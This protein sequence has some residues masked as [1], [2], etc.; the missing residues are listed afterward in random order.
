MVE[1]AELPRKI[2]PEEKTPEEMRKEFKVVKGGGGRKRS[3]WIKIG[4]G[5]GVPVVLGGGGAA[6]YFIQQEQAQGELC[7]VSHTR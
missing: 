3:K 2:P 6:A 4:A 1:P 7:Q 5:I